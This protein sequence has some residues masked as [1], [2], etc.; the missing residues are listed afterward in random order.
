M[1]SEATL[2]RQLTC[3]QACAKSHQAG[4]FGW[5]MVLELA[6]VAAP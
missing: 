5:K 6:G 3:P 4:D 1:N 2:V